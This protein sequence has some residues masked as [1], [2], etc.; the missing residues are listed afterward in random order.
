MCSRLVSETAQLS[1]ERHFGAVF[2]G[3]KNSVSRKR[4]VA[5]SISYSQPKARAAE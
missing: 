3:L 2:S 1:L 5:R 4:T